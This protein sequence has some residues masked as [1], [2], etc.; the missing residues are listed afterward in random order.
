MDTQ[1]TSQTILVRLFA[2][3]F[4]VKIFHY[5]TQYYGAHKAADKFFKNFLETS[6]KFLE[7]YQGKYG[8]IVFDGKSIDLAIPVLTDDNIQAYLAKESNYLSNNL[9]DLLHNENDGD[10]LNIR[11]EL[12]AIVD[13]F[14]YLLIFK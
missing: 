1:K 5:R 13:Q 12:Q 7:V 3:I 11:D 14:K 9:K 6:D 10:L 2:L 8:R 4:S